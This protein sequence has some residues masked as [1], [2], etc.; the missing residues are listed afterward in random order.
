MIYIRTKLLS[1]TRSGVW[2]WGAFLA[3]A[4]YS[5]FHP[6]PLLANVC[7]PRLIHALTYPPTAIPFMK[8]FVGAHAMSLT[9]VGQQQKQCGCHFK[10]ELSEV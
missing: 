8:L 2:T 10:G 1:S 6:L 3:L 7:E 4:V 9:T 5:I